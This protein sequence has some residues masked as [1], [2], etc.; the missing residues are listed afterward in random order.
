MSKKHLIIYAADV[1]GF[2]TKGP[3]SAVEALFEVI[4]ANIETKK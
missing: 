4:S 2:E 3:E 1:P